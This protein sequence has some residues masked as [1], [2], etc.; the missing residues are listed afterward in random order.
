METS[1]SY[2]QFIK[3]IKQNIVRSRYFAA[4][5]ANQEQLRLYFKT[6]SL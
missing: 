6:E 2:K 3:N 4:R 1:V 5:S